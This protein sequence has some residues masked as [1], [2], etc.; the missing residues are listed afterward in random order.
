MLVKIS[1]EFNDMKDMI[2]DMR[3]CLEF[4]NANQNVPWAEWM[5]DSHRRTL[6]KN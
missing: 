2:G 3:N 4:I 1:K 6:E 5:V